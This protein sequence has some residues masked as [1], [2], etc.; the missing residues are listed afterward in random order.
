M[1]V[2]GWPSFL[3]LQLS[4]SVITVSKGSWWMQNSPWIQVPLSAEGCSRGL[5]GSQTGWGWGSISLQSPGPPL[6][7]HPCTT[8]QHS[9]AFFRLFTCCKESVVGRTVLWKK[10]EWGFL[11]HHMSL[12]KPPELLTWTA[13]AYLVLIRSFLITSCTWCLISSYTVSKISGNT[14]SQL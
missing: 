4:L 6:L 10:N 14:D 13:V 11:R 5:R 7:L 8:A 9:T 2:Y 3:N 1:P 12:L